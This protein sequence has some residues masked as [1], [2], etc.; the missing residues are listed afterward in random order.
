MV[1]EWVQIPENAQWKCLSNPP[2]IIPMNDLR[3][4]IE[5]EYCWCKPYIDEQ[6]N[7]IVHNSMDGREKYE[8]GERK[9]S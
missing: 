1:S 6:E 8:T 7:V 9:L 4:H 2:E 3:D 5:G